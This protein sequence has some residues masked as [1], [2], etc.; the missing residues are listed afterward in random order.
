[1]FDILPMSLIIHCFYPIDGMS[2]IKYIYIILLSRHLT[3]IGKI[4]VV[5]VVY[6][7][8]TFKDI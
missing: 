5:L 3:S 6:A 1:M 4:N 7:Y 8:N 2:I